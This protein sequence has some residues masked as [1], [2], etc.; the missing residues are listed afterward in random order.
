M[1]SSG[2]PDVI[3]TIPNEK[4]FDSGVD[5]DP[6]VEPDVIPA[7]AGEVCFFS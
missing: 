3:D 7:E 4:G 2:T 1:C 5:V 6:T